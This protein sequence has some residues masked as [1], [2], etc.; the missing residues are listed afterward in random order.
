ML[1][2]GTWCCLALPTLITLLAGLSLLAGLPRLAGV[3]RLA[4]LSGLPLRPL[5]P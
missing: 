2:C 1:A 4:W 3:P 5:L